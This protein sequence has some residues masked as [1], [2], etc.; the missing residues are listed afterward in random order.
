MATGGAS[1]TEQNRRSQYLRDVQKKRADLLAA[2]Q[3]RF[4]KPEN[5]TSLPNI[6]SFAQRT[7]EDKP[8]TIPYED[9]LADTEE[10]EE[11]AGE[12]EEE[13]IDEEER[14]TQFASTTAQTILA[15]E[16]QETQGEE[17]KKQTV[18]QK[19]IKKKAEAGVR[20]GAVYITDLIAGAF[21]MGSAGVGFFIDWIIWAFSLGYL[22]VE[23]FYGKYLMKG[24]DPFISEPSWD[25]FPL[26]LPNEWVDK[27]IIA[28]DIL[29]F[30]LAFTAVVALIVIIAGIMAVLDNPL[31][32]FLDFFDMR[33][34]IFQ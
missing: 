18:L 23:L 26:P 16:Q 33:I 21:D 11:E 28:A 10:M 32:S 12:D 1:S 22:N 5:K 31:A 34:N 8:T 4:A 19:E 30:L 9:P 25:P 29:V 14:R 24:K 15:S 2:A 6:P 13:E 27:L 20:R 17:S 7:M 3:L